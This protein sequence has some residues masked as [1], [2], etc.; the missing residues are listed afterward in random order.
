M[1]ACHRLGRVLFQRVGDGDQA[2]RRVADYVAVLTKDKR[3]PEAKRER[4]YFDQL[5]RAP[6]PVRLCKFADSLHNLRDTD[7]AHRPKAA[8]KARKLLRITRSA[9]GLERPIA[10]L[11]AELDR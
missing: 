2:G 6:L 4:V 5:A 10:L 9:R 1:Q 3:L 8:G 7:A 11:R